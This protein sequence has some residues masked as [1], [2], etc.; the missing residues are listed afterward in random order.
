M[1]HKG[2]AWPVAVAILI[3]T[4]AVAVGAAFLVFKGETPVG[5]GGI[6]ENQGGGGPSSEN[7][8]GAIHLT[9]AETKRMTPT[10]GYETG[11]FNRIFYNASR[12]KLYL[13]MASLRENA[14]KPIPSYQ[15]YV[16]YELDPNLNFTGISG[17]V[18]NLPSASDY[19]IAS[20]GMYY[21][22]LTGD[23]KGWL[24]QKLDL[25]F[26]AI[27]NVVVKLDDKWE[28]GNDQLMNYTNGKLYLAAL[29]DNLG[30]GE[31][32]FTG[33]HNYTTYPHLFVYDTSLSMLD[34]RYLFDETNIPAGGSIIFNKNVCHM[35]TADKFGGDLYVYRWD[36]NWSYLGKK[37][38]ATSA[39]WSQG[40]LYENGYYYVAYQRPPFG[41]NGGA[42]ILAVFDDNWNKITSVYVTEPSSTSSANRPWIIK[43]GN[44]IY[45][46]YDVGTFAAVGGEQPDWQCYI[47][48]IEVTK[49]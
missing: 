45:V 36:S 4:I 32:Y 35:V 42:I 27:D 34:N 14:P 13:T 37:S 9:L 41:G 6:P 5:P 2:I 31:N 10:E 33:K 23:P 8:R 18:S 39:H 21:Y 24:L 47:S 19:A 44:K 38:L 48:V 22:L 7:V 30:T 11:V 26:Q 28:A 17:R 1:S 46:S 3:V 12:K 49:G 29:Y 20:D 16:Y 43:L 40:L 25:D 15:D